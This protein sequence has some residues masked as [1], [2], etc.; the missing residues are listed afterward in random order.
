MDYETPAFLLTSD[1]HTT[2]GANPYGE[3]KGFIESSI[4]L[5]S[6]GIPAT[7][8]VAGNEIAN[9]P[10]TIGQMFTG[11]KDEYEI[12]SNRQRIADFDSDLAKYYDAHEMGIDAAGFIAGS[13]VP[14]LGATKVFRA[15]QLVTREAIAAGSMGKMTANALGLLAPQREKYLAAAIEQ[16]GKTG[17]VFA[18]TEANTLKALSHGV[19][20]NFLEGAVFTGAVNA[21]MHN[22]PVLDQRNA[23]DLSWDVLT[24]GMINAVIGG[25]IAGI[26][27][28][29]AIKR[30][31]NIA[32]EALQ[33]FMRGAEPVES[34]MPSDRMLFRLRQLEA[35]PE[36]PAAFKYYERAGREAQRTKESLWR[37]IR[38][39]LGEITGGDQQ[40]AD[41]YM[42]IIEKLPLEKNIANLVES[43]AIVRVTAT[44][45]V[46]KRMNAAYKKIKDNPLGATQEDK[47][48]YL[49]YSV[50]FVD[51]L[52]GASLSERP[53]VLTLADKLKAGE[54]IT[55]NPKTNEVIVGSYKRFKHEN[56]QYRGYNILGQTHE[57]I[58]SRYVWAESLPKQVDDG[59]FIVHEND[60]PLL[61]KAQKDGLT[62]LKVIPESGAIAEART[63]ST[64]GEI[65]EFV[66]VKQA[67][68]AARLAK[69]ETMPQSLE[70]LV[71]KLKHHLGINFNTVSDAEGGYYG[72][73]KRVEQRLG[74]GAKIEGDAIVAEA[75]GILKR[76]I[77]EV[78]RTLKHEEGHAIFQ[79]LLDAHGVTRQ[80]LDTTWL[81]LRDEVTA[82]SQKARPALWKATDAKSIEYRQNWHEL[83]AD[84][85][86]YLS[87]N[88]SQLSKYPEFEKFAGHLVRPIPQEVLDA[89][90]RRSFKPSKAEI[91][92]IVNASEENIFGAAEA[93]DGWNL[94]E[95][96]R[97]IARNNGAVIDPHTMPRY[98]KVITRSDRLA[99]ADGNLL[100]G[101]AIVEQK[102]KLWQEA[103]D[104]IAAEVTGSIVP[105]EMLPSSAGM[106]NRIIGQDVGAGMVTSENGAYGSWSSFFSYVGQRTHNLKKVLQE[107]TA[108][109][110]NPTLMKMATNVDDAIELSVLNERMRGLPNKYHLSDDGTKL[111]YGKPPVMDDFVDEAAYQRA[112]TKY[113]EE[114]ESL[115]ADNI[116]GTIEI[117]SPLVQKL[118]ADHINLNNGRRISLQK[119]HSNNGYQD[120]FDEGVF[121]PIPRNPKDT[122]FFAYVVDDTVTGRGHSK[123]IYAKDAETLEQMRNEIMSDPDLREQGLRVLSKAESEEY[124]KSVGQ[125]EFERTLSDNYIN[126]ALARKGK[127]E[128]FLPL[129]DPNK[130]VTDFLAWHQGRDAALVRTTV[131]HKYARDFAK[132]RTAAEPATQAAKSKFGYISP[133]AYAENTVNNPAA[134]LIKMA[135][136]IS[137]VDE[138]PLWTPLNKF[139]D[140]AFST[141]VDKVGKAFSQATSPEHLLQVNE[142]LA[143]AGY[144][145]VIVDAPLY[146][147]MNGSVP[148]NTLSNIVNKANA[149]IAGFAIRSDPFNALNNAVGS[150][151][152][153]G[154]ETKA[155][156]KTLRSMS[157]EGAAEFDAIAKIAVPGSGGDLTLSPAKLIASRIGKFHSDK[158][159]REWFKRHGFISSISEQYDQVLDNLGLALARGDESYINKAFTGMKTLGDKA[160]KWSA[161]KLAEEFN[162]YV[163]AGVAK[164]ITD[165]AV[166]RGVMTAD[167]QMS[168]I[169]TFVN[170][171]QGNYLAS[172]RPVIF[173]GP[174]GQAIGLFQTYQFNLL[175][176]V[177]RHIGEGQWKNV[178]V[179]AGLQGGIYGMNG[180]PAFNAINTHIIGSA[181]G[182]PE[183]KNLYDAIFSGAGKEAG[184]WLLY[185]GLSNGLG[186]FHPDLKTNVYTRGDLNPRHVTLI[187]TDP[188]KVP[189]YQATERFFSNIKEGYTKVQ[190]GA[191]VWT[192][193]LRGVE[194]NGISRPLAGMA[195]ILEAAG[196]A[197]KKVVSTNQQGNMLMAHDLY[198]LNSL[199]RVMGAK[200]LDEAIVNDTMFRMN[201]YR[202]A[203]AQKRKVLGEAVKNTILS[204][205]PLEPDQITK[206]ADVYARSGGKQTEFGAWMANQY[207]NASVSQAEQMRQ[208]LGADRS[209]ALQIIMNGGP[210]EE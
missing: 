150:A 163:A 184:E 201:T 76:P 207:K 204:G 191:D 145:K 2:L 65:A 170:R 56:N 44:S 144:N 113:A 24:G 27:A 97:A 146:E 88:P 43:R 136:D 64:A 129:T 79:S 153:L 176:Q 93:A 33:P 21:T 66:K 82:L 63:L 157:P 45:D 183:H 78:I 23:S 30:G 17:N 175:Q 86:Q 72:F 90:S 70:D 67:D 108:E 203:D 15:G 124:Y 48:E 8:I 55:V 171:T 41:M 141:V 139:L 83:F 159:E 22:S 117:K 189:I 101:M 123:M 52:T 130:I 125:F 206:F 57:N 34:A 133:Q 51:N 62:S 180:L 103:A 61:Q 6:K 75:S 87:R 190:M 116:P 196:R 60:I 119:I 36:V 12:V 164:D 47:D 154:P 69:A 10:A 178:A 9:I 7:L 156:I 194:Q 19:Y 13:L 198:T 140:S 122:P 98:S 120:R 38:S 134:N 210:D 138:Y 105:G 26:T 142:A 169:N 155:L 137:K 1:A 131:E 84:T 107:K 85:F 128:S 195:Q 193:F 187:P 49:R 92:K 74:A 59:S 147:A 5:V 104:R 71:G 37:D 109:I 199:M 152:L 197:D 114:L 168:Y 200:P 121:Y 118:V 25:G 95:Q 205:K 143:K 81:A 188:S 32:E 102:E 50:G 4:D 18:F 202:T 127:S 20:Q 73:F 80:N 68:V 126:S 89:V 28:K 96:V 99:D 160:E 135:L 94:R 29:Y 111:V 186:L 132:F 40:L 182:N 158:V 42:A 181:G 77:A 151:V 208:S 162:R 53:A 172:Q 31:A 110:L 11:N 106:G 16:I 161:N 58:E 209:S 115:A 3:D 35:I 179:M 166:K 149:I 167:V 185:G 91:A 54:K 112:A 173:Q 14:G 165:I 46:E 174:I 39:D 177:F 148:R 100:E 192:T